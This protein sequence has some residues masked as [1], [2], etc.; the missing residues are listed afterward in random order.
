MFSDGNKKIILIRFRSGGVRVVQWCTGTRKLRLFC[1][2]SYR[3]CLHTTRIFWCQ[4]REYVPFTLD[5]KKTETDFLRKCVTRNLSC[6]SCSRKVH[7][8]GR[9]LYIYNNN[10]FNRLTFRKNQPRKPLIL[11]GFL[12]FKSEV[13]LTK[14]EVWLT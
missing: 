10:R 14:S 1:M 6:F 11:L 12:I 3:L 13:W 9:T 7:S 2:F 5:T 8:G 4:G